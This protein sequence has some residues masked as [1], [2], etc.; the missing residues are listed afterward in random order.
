M[1]H[2][3][4]AHGLR[5]LVCLLVTTAFAGAAAAATA[6]LTDLRIGVHGDHTRVVIETDAE[7]PYIV[8]VNDREVIVHV[9]AAAAA[10]AITAKSPHLVWA[11][12]E[13]TPIGADVRLSLK[14]PAEEARLTDA[15]ERGVKVE[16]E[17]G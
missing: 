8:D 16:S 4:L 10:E 2:A 6:N 13:P 9:D 7:A 3:P 1:I 14:Q 12:V 5:A 15:G 17:T 11:K